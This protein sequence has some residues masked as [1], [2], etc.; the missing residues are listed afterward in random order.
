MQVDVT[1]SD[2][3]KRQLKV[4]VPAAELGERFIARLDAVKDQVQIKGFRKGKV[5]VS[6]IKKMYGRSLMV[7][8]MQAAVDETSRKAL[9][10]RNERPALQPKIDLPADAA[11]IEK[12]IEGKADLSYGMTFEVLP[13]F[14]LTDFAGL[15]LERMVAD[16]EEAEVEKALGTLV[17]RSTAFE[18][19]PDRAAG[20][21]DQIKMNFIGRIDGEAFEGGTATDV[22]LV[23][24]QSGFIPGFEDGLKGVKASEKRAVTATFPADYN[25]AHLAGKVAVFEVDVT[26]VAAPKTPTVDDEFAKTLG[27]ADVTALRGMV[28][29]QLALEHDRVTRARLKRSLLDVLETTHDFALPASLVDSEF[30]SVWTEVTNTMARD[31]KSFESEGK[32]E[33]SAR[34]EYRKIAERRVRL[35]LII[36]EV[37][38][39]NKIQVTQDEMRMA[40]MEQARQFRGQEKFVYE[41]YEKNPDAVAQLRAPIFEEKVVDHIVSLAKPTERKVSREELFKPLADEE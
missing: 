29:A 30:D 25:A 28:N 6:H 34:V 2:G 35:G 36:G 37:G 33:E 17:A 8:V 21:G 18:A 22:S 13:T 31:K 40:L 39:Q 16:V 20:D 15:K 3:L 7:E 38:E 9:T 14:T 41:Y 4:V 32:T 5:P 12:V 27:A 23:F 10:E 26:E 1:S 11:E 19:V 24:G